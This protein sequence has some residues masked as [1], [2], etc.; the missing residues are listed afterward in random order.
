[1]RRKRRW[2]A[3]RRSGAWIRREKRWAIYLRDDCTCVWCGA[4]PPT[5]SL[6]HLFPRGSRLRDN[7]PRR[8][9]T[10]CFRCNGRWKEARLS[11]R[12]RDCRNAGGLGPVLERLRRARLP[13]DKTAA[14]AFL[15]P[16]KVDCEPSELW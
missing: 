6:D 16:Q 1:M 3:G 14:R 11:D 9:V 15:A 12:L 13:I 4:Q 8:L 2:K 7:D 5:L 10:A